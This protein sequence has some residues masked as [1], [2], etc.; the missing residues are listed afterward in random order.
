MLC[1][2]DGCDKVNLHNFIRELI[3]ELSIYRSRNLDSRS[4]HSGDSPQHTGFLR[5][6]SRYFRII[7]FW[8][9][10]NLQRDS[11]VNRKKII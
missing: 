6:K 5:Y 7:V 10:V 11:C 3:K 1:H 2:K 9:S 8:E 4:N